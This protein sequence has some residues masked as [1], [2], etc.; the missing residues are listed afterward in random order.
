MKAGTFLAFLC[1]WFSSLFCAVDVYVFDVGQGNCIWVS[2]DVISGRNNGKK[3]VLIVDCGSGHGEGWVKQDSFMPN[4]RRMGL[5]DQV[6]DYALWITH[7]H[8]DH[9]NLLEQNIPNSKGSILNKVGYVFVGVGG[10]WQEE[11]FDYWPTSSLPGYARNAKREIEKKSA[12]AQEKLKKYQVKKQG[13]VKSSL[14]QICAYIKGKKDANTCFPIK[15][16]DYSPEEIRALQRALDDFTA[17]T[18][19]S[20]R[21]LLPDP[22][23]RYNDGN[24]PTNPNDQS[25]VLALECAGECVIFTEDAPGDLFLALSVEDKMRV[26]RADILIA[27]H[28]GS[29]NNKENLWETYDVNSEI[30]KRYCTIVSSIPVAKDFIPNKEFMGGRPS[31]AAFVA[32]PHPVLVYDQVAGR[33]S[34]GEQA[35]QSFRWMRMFAII[36]PNPGNLEESDWGD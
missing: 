12:D 36:V 9:F 4:L 14:G 2:V 20:L 29:V 33:S 8:A 7:L 23:K 18:N 31:R 27:P 17:E 26:S 10:G 15:V 24:E 3:K 13:M 22:E 6:C 19:C 11:G 28:H 16:W 30:R 21:P 32:E 25:L 1:C 5:F 35:R 34:T